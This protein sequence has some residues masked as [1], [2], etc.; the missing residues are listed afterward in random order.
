[1]DLLNEYSE[2]IIKDYVDAEI[3]GKKVKIKEVENGS[4]YVYDTNDVLIDHKRRY[5][6][7][8]VVKND[9]VTGLGEV[10]QGLFKNHG[11][12]LYYIDATCVPSKIAPPYFKVDDTKRQEY[13]IDRIR[14]IINN[15]RPMILP[16][17]PNE[18]RGSYSTFVDNHIVQYRDSNGNTLI[19]FSLDIEEWPNTPTIYDT[20]DGGTTRR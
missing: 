16:S 11:C 4:I 3:L 19:P 17:N 20:L 15:N 12:K 10:Y 9:D 7:V 13:T 6:R 2:I 18:N 8:C 14:E 5:I 1:M